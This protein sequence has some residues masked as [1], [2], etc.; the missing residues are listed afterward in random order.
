MDSGV[1]FVKHQCSM[2][3]IDT[4]VVL[5]ASGYASL[6]LGRAGS[7]LRRLILS[8]NWSIREPGIAV[9]R[10]RNENPSIHCDVSAV[11][12]IFGCG[13][14]GYSIFLPPDGSISRF[15]SSVTYPL[16][17]RRL[18][19]ILWIYRVITTLARSTFFLILFYVDLHSID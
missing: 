18:M 6:G 10:F 1:A 12:G 14:C 4:A 15:S 7:A 2:L 5:L 13:L 17:P 11:L 16:F 3:R 19:R 8:A 9:L